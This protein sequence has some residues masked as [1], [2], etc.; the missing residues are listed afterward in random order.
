VPPPIDVETKS[1]APRVKGTL[2]KRPQ[3]A[4]QAS[5]STEAQP[6]DSPTEED[7]AF[8]AAECEDPDCTGCDNCSDV[9]VAINPKRRKVDERARSKALTRD[10]INRIRSMVTNT[11]NTVT[12]TEP[13]LNQ[14]SKANKSELEGCLWRAY[15]EVLHCHHEFK[16]ILREVCDE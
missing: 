3:A 14:G 4:T 15:Y 6:D 5:D 16:R 13:I 2:G 1:A 8:I 11:G 9:L 7:K 10:D 12:L